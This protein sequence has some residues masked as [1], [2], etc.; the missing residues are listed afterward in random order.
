MRG[1][2]R[3]KEQHEASNSRNEPNSKA[4]KV[5]WGL[6]IKHKLKHFIWRCLHGVLPVNEVIKRRIGSGEDK[7]RGCGEGTETLEH[8]FFFCRHSENIWKAAPIDWDG[9]K[10]FRHSFW[11]WWNSL[12][13]AQDRIEG[14]NH[15][16][17]TVNIL[18]QI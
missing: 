17:L 13:D 5:L 15:I 10:E 9:L 12:M 16:A 1:E 14:K 11:H 6:G 4:W 8:K 7:C 18:W 2:W 3:R